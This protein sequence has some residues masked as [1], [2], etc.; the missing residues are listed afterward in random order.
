MLVE[1]YPAV[2]PNP[3]N[4]GNCQDQH[5]RDAWKVLQ[6]MLT[7]DASGTLGVAFEIDRL[8]FGRVEGVAFWEQVC[9]EG[10]ILGVS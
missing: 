3:A 4:F 2:Y 10:W 6:W 8:P 7:A 5:C 1:S 9:F